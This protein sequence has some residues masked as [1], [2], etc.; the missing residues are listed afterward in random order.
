MPD[1]DWTLLGE[2]PHSDHRI[3]RVRNDRYRLAGGGPDRD[4]VVIESP[5]WINVV[6]VTDDGRV[7]LIRQFRHGVRAVTLEIP[8]G[9]VD[10]GEDPLAAAARELREE[11]G[12]RARSVRPLGGVWPNPAIQANTCHTFLAEGCVPEGAPEPDPYERIEVL[13]VPLA[14]VPRLVRSGEIRHALVVAAFG[15][16]GALAP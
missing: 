10:P 16:M 14:D 7:V 8:G 13:T 1:R 2:R 5:D 3:F 4:F 12:Y 11:T 6:P 9:M 15:L